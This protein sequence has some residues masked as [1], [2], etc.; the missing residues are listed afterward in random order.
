MVEIDGRHYSTH[1][2]NPKLNPI[3]SEIVVHTLQGILDFIQ[4]ESVQDPIIHVCTES[5]VM[6]F[7][8]VIEPWK[9]RH[10]YVHSS[11]IKIEGFQ[12]S[13]R[14]SIEESIIEIYSKFVDNEDKKLLIDFLSSIRGEEVVASEDDGISQHVTTSN[15]IGRLENTKIRPL[16]NLRPYRT[17]NEIEQIES[18]FLLRLFP[19]EKKLP[20]V[21]LFETDGGL[22]RNKAI[23]SIARWF[24][25]N[26]FVVENKIK[27][28][29]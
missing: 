11:P 4:A 27:V 20:N 17:F 9:S 24:V 19:V 12:F 2:L 29:S 13:Q 3:Q 15:K 14:L 8:K 1:A 23:K 26:D 18:R 5:S 7:S 6:C 25:D 10:C 16:V 22:W 28:I 21:T